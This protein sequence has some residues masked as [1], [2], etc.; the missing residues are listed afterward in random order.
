M[1]RRRPYG[2]SSNVFVCV[3]VCV[4][5]Y[6]RVSVSMCV[7]TRVKVSI[8][9]P[10]KYL[11]VWASIEEFAFQHFYYLRNQFLG[12]INCIFSTDYK[13]LGLKFLLIAERVLNGYSL[14]FACSEKTVCGIESDSRTFSFV[15][16][17]YILEWDILGECGYMDT[18]HG[19]V[20]LDAVIYWLGRDWCKFFMC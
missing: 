20:R 9:F 15:F 6:V 18:F 3:F 2:E 1:P 17:S 13:D 4:C 7:Y 5:R 8:W 12:Q 19:W 10:L 11:S 14:V 16:I